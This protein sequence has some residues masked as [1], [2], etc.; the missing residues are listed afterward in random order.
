MIKFLTYVIIVNDEFPCHVK[1][2]KNNYQKKIEIMEIILK[3]SL[4][5]FDKLEICWRL[6]L[7]LLRGFRIT[8][9]GS[10]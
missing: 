1:P 10:F 4:I 9:H 6:G 7:G 8:I 3:N 2:K 5:G